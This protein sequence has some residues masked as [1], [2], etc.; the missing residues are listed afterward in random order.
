MNDD[1][2][3]SHPL[4]TI[5]YTTQLSLLH[6]R[7]PRSPRVSGV[8]QLPAGA[9]QSVLEPSRS[10]G[11]THALRGAA[12]KRR[13][14]GGEGRGGREGGCTV[15][16]PLNLRQ[17][18]ATHCCCVLYCALCCALCCALFFH[19]AG[20]SPCVGVYSLSWRIITASA[21]HSPLLN[22][23]P[24]VLSL[25][26]ADQ[27]IP[28]NPPTGQLRPE[29]IHPRSALHQPRHQP[30]P[31]LAHPRPTDPLHLPGGERRPPQQGAGLPSLPAG[32]VSET[33]TH[34]LSRMLAVRAGADE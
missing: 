26:P 4:I 15:T 8:G 2:T 24:C 20:L 25:L 3:T 23:P 11:R 33:R 21:R 14:G 29:L 1:C 17:Q 10:F 7:L 34:Q 18:R 13:R 12:G 27:Q 31:H 5:P 19:V 9:A 22:P 6:S 32:A 28:E 16:L 30:Q